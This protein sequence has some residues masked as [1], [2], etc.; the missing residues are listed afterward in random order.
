MATQPHDYVVTRAGRRYAL[1]ERTTDVER[2][3]VRFRRMCRFEPETGCVVWTGGQT[4]G[5]GHN[6]PYPSFWFAGQRW[7]GHRWAA[8]FIHGQDIDGFQTDHC[9]PHIAIPNTLC[10]EHVQSLTP[11][12]N[13][14]LQ[15]ERRRN[16]IHLQVGLL[17]YSDLYGP[18]PE[19][20][21]DEDR[22]PFFLP[23]AW[24][25]NGEH[26]GCADHCP[27]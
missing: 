20:V 27:F 1:D 15:H 14:E 10:V 13:R 24:L 4:Q 26:H 8:K 18:E 11:R 17:H 2:A 22:V 3:L 23:P 25:T 9:C 6:V 21:P 12:L 5:R 19:P 7:F 16:F